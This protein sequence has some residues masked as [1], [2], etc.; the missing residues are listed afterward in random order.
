MKRV[1]SYEVLGELGR[2]GMGVVYLARQPSVDRLVALKVLANGGGAIGEQLREEAG[3]LASLQHPHIVPVLDV[4]EHEGRSFFVMPYCAGGTVAELLSARGSLTPGQ[5]AGVVVAVAEALA[6]VH[7]R[8]LVHGD[9]KPSN[10]LLSE[11]GDPYLADFGLS[12]LR[13]D[14]LE[15]GLLIGSLAYL[16]PEARAGAAPTSRADAYAL[17]LVGYELLT[18]SRPSRGPG[19]EAPLTLAVAAPWVPVD[20]VSAIEAAASPDPERRPGDLRAFATWVRRTVPHEPL[21]PPGRGPLR[22]A[23]PPPDDLDDA[24]TRVGRRGATRDLAQQS[25]GPAAQP[26]AR[27]RSRATLVALVLLP[28]VAALVGG[29]LGVRSVLARSGPDTQLASSTGGTPQ[30]PEDEQTELVTPSPQAVSAPHAQEAGVDPALDALRA[31]CAGNDL[32]ACDRLAVGAPSGSEMARFGATCG[33]RPSAVAGS[34]A[35]REIEVELPAGSS[36]RPTQAPRPA[37]SPSLRPAA[38][39]SAR[40]TPSASPSPRPSPPAASARPAPPSPSAAPRPAQP[41]P[42]AAQPAPPPAQPSPPPAA[43]PPPPAPQPEPDP[44]EG[45]EEGT[46]QLLDEEGHSSGVLPPGMGHGWSVQGAAG[47]TLYAIVYTEEGALDTK[48]ELESPDGALVAADDDCGADPR[49]PSANRRDPYLELTLPTTGQF[50][51]TVLG[52]DADDTGPYEL[53]VSVE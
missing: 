37:P 43:Q 30:Q 21:T 12:G 3:V 23:G 49:C 19:A 24:L 51:L 42:P 28:I 41:T 39:P 4:G 9:V 27:R 34:C 32:E 45:Q 20:L 17:G 47:Q 10:I 44:A 7:A 15:G 40:P 35:D 36:D 11:A 5:A 6:A 33:D 31:G 16:A 18:G 53:Y 26:V 25:I 52:Y 14:L 50:N 2:G 13:S 48:L 46:Y 22:Q 1:G 38:S 29:G 8:G